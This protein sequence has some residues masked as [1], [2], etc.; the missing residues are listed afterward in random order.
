MRQHLV[1][2]L[3]LKEILQQVHHSGDTSLED[4]SISNRMLLTQDGLDLKEVS[5]LSLLIY[6]SCEQLKQPFSELC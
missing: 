3:M 4:S 1:N 6:N 5:V 2:R